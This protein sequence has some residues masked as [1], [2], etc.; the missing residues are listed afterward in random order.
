MN[1]EK[2]KSFSVS[3]AMLYESYLKV[4]SKNGCA[5]IDKQTIDMFSL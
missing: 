4:C 1:E 2:T 3:K 5:G